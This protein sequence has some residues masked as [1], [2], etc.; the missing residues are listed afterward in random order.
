MIPLRLGIGAPISAILSYAILST[1]CMVESHSQGS[2]NLRPRPVPLCPVPSPAA[3]VAT[4][5][6]NDTDSISSPPGEGI[7]VLVDYD[8]GGHWH[9]WTVCDTSISD[10]VCAYDVTAQVLGG[11]IPTNVIGE[12]LEGGEAAGLACSDTAFLSSIT[13]FGTDSLRFTTA[14]GAS[15]QITGALDRTVFPDVIFWAF[16]GA[17]QTSATNPVTLTPASP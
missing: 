11:D 15:V 9:I 17:A 16:G 5:D 2:E 12:D 4:I 10:S 6:T 13:D 14:P 3:E 1:G 8:T 7:G